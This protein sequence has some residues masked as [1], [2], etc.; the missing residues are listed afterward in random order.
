MSV[1]MIGGS[2]LH[3]AA[4]LFKDLKKSDLAKSAVDMPVDSVLNRFPAGTPVFEADWLN[5]AL[6]GWAINPATKNCAAIYSWELCIDLCKRN[7]GIDFAAAGE[8]L[9]A[10]VQQAGGN[11]PILVWGLDVATN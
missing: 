4:G 3:N 5:D 8:Y 1:K 6:L 10:G 7:L 11:A 9:A 2:I